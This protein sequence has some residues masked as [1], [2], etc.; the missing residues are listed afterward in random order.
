MLSEKILI[1]AELLCL[2][3]NI[4]HSSHSRIILEIQSKMFLKVM[5]RWDSPSV[6]NLLVKDLTQTGEEPG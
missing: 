2:S 4:L 6:C 5:K 3:E 1:G